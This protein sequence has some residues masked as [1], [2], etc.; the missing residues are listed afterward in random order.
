VLAQALAHRT[1]GEPPE[2]A[3]LE[4][5]LESEAHTVSSARARGRGG[6]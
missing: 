2:L 4:D 3:P 1:G 5:A 6:R